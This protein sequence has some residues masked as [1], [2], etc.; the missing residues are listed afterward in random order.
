M[1]I[2]LWKQNPCIIIKHPR[3]DEHWLFDSALH[4]K[5]SA[6]TINAQA[7]IRTH[8][9][10]KNHPFK[11]DEVMQAGDLQLLSFRWHQQIL[12]FWLGLN[13][14]VIRSWCISSDANPMLLNHESPPCSWLVSVWYRVKL[15]KTFYLT[16]NTLVHALTEYSA[17]LHLRTWFRET[18]SSQVGHVDANHWYSFDTW[19]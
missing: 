18:E 17:D 9:G 10:A 6:L 2:L 16:K 15:I 4:I 5:S 7:T 14:I 8:L 12:Q 19:I 1:H 11:R 13:P 3:P